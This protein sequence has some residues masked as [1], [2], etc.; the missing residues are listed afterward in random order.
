MWLDSSLNPA[1]LAPESAERSRFSILADDGGRFGQA[2][3]HSSGLTRVSAGQATVTIDSPF[4][5]WLDGV[6]GRR[7]L[8]APE[9]YP[10][11]FT[12]GWL[13]YLGYEL[14]RETGGNDVP[15]PT[16]DACLIFAGRAVVLD[17][18]E[19]TAWLLALD[20]PDAG[21]WLVP[22]ARPSPR[23]RP[24][25]AQRPAPADPPWTTLLHRTPPHP[26]SLATLHRQG[27]GG[28][29]QGKGFRGPA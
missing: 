13:G 17:H 27:R 8:R 26:A 2:V 9:G 29:L 14:K 1:G 7:A 20:T 25:R 11:E 24:V 10:C 28:R 22:P 6:W 3:R 19:G 12:L 15:A 5:R 4:F 18:A 16:P 21:D 23:R